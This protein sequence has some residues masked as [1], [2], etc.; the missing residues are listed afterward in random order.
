MAGTA[1]PLPNPIPPATTPPP[2]TSISTLNS[3]WL[4]ATDPVNPQVAPLG[5][6]NTFLFPAIDPATASNISNYSLV[7]TT[8]NTD[9]SQY[10][11]SATLVPEAATAPNGYVTAYNAQIDL[12]FTP[13]MPF[14]NYE[15]IAHTQ[16][17]PVPGP[18]RRRGQ[19]S[20]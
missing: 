12:T 14:G 17:A 4:T 15:F 11:T 18:G 13:G 6:P 19:L 20:R 7:N 2:P 1:L 9:E 10:I 8:T 5:T 3:L 16:R